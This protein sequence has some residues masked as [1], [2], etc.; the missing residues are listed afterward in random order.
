MLKCNLLLNVI[1]SWDTFESMIHNIHCLRVW[2]SRL[3]SVLWWTYIRITKL[4]ELRNPVVHIVRDYRYFLLYLEFQIW[5]QH[6]I[7]EKIIHSM[8]YLWWPILVTAITPKIGPI[9][10]K[11][12]FNKMGPKCNATSFSLFILLEQRL[13]N[14]VYNV[15]SWENV[16]GTQ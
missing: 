4:V 16:R 14:A 15:I 3:W 13:N 6:E 5:N 2:F 12:W 9:W 8:T 7:C 1:Y 11:L 10:R